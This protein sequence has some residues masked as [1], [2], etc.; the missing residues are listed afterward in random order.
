[1]PRMKFLSVAAL[2]ALCIACSGAA[3]AA[4]SWTA[5]GS[6]FPAALVWDEAAAVSVDAVND[7]DT[8]W[9]SNYALKSVE[10]PTA[11]ATA[12]DRWGTTSVSVVGTWTPTGTPY[13][14]DFGIT[15]PPISTLAYALPIGPTTPPT[16]A[17]L[18]SSWMLANGGTLIT[19][20]ISDNPIAVT[21]F[22]DG[23]WAAAWVEQCA[24]RVPLLVGGYPDGTY[25]PNLAVTRDQ[26]AVFVQRAFVLPLGTYTGGFSDVPTGYWAANQIQSCVD[27]GVVAGYPDGTYRPTVVVTR[28][29]MAVFVARAMAGG[30]ANV[31]TGPATATFTD[32][33][34]SYW[35]FD[36]VEYAV[37]NNVVG[38]YPDGTY[39]PTVN[40]DRG[41]MAVFVWRSAIMPTGS[42]VVLDGP[43]VTAVDVPTALYDGWTSLPAG[44]AADPGDAY[45]GI[46]AVRAAAADITVTFE[47]RDA[48]TPTTPATG[49]YT[50]T[51]VV[52]AAQ[53]AGAKAAAAATGNPYLN[54]SWDIPAGLAADDY[55]LVVT[56]DG[57]EVA[58]KPAFTILP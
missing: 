55:L 52:T 53:V 43:A 29:Q 9:D 35:A 31:P 51:V 17:T 49:A 54:V 40:V 57:N 39:R 30:E 6:D 2:F 21:R 33:P 28:D 5:S 22:A 4:D 37:A 13:T 24:G 14:F 58:R 16:V 12:V 10:G 19:T 23:A 45:V 27:A 18:G 32:V 1:M 8:T 34:T 50:S 7:G 47:L 46:D 11:T 48:D 20:D 42:I 36:H 15:A 3:L 38:G 41:Q 44:L 56:I 25:R 26:M